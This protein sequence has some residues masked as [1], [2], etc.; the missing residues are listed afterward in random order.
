MAFKYLFVV[1]NWVNNLTQLE[2]LWQEQGLP[3]ERDVE[4]QIFAGITSFVYIQML[5]AAFAIGGHQVF[6]DFLGALFPW[7]P[8]GNPF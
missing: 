1:G 4:H 8:H 3:F 5:V 2:V 7:N 6:F